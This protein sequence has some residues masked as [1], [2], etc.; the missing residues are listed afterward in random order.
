ML[1]RQLWR[2]EQR[3]MTIV[4]Q[5]QCL[6]IHWLTSAQAAAEVER[7][8][9]ALQRHSLEQEDSSEDVYGMG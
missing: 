6:R 1:R 2:D 5:D 4:G 9:L 8:R 7:G 3:I